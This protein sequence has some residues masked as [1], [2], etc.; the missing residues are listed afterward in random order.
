MTTKKATKKAPV[1]KPAP[2]KLTAAQRNAEAFKILQLIVEKTNIDDYCSEGQDILRRAADTVDSR[3]FKSG[4]LEVSLDPFYQ[5]W[6]DIK[7]TDDFEYE[8]H[9]KNTRTGKVQIEH[10]Y[11]YETTIEMDS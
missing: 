7:P 5:N 1:K 4:T 8:I 10:G 2:K 11:A 9:V 6:D 3:K